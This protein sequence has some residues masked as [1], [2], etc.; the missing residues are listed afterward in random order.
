MPLRSR[1]RLGLLDRALDDRPEVLGPEVQRHEA[2]IELGHLEQVGGQPV[3]SLDLATALLQ[4]LVPRG[5]V[6][7]GTLAQQLV[8]GPQR[9]DGRPQLV[10]DVGHEL[11]AAVTVGADDVDGLLESL[12]HVVERA[13]ELGQ[14]R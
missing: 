4:E 9:G 10:R 3:E 5:R 14:L 1:D 2:R 11:A 6:I 7:H 8:E 12:R 13:G